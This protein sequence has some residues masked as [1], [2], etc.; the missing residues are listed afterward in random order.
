[1]IAGLE[2]QGEIKEG[3]EKCQ[4][5]ID[6][7]PGRLPLEQV[8]KLH[9]VRRDRWVQ[10]RLDALRALAKPD[11]VAEMD[12]AVAARFKAA[13]SDGSIDALKAFLAYFGEQP[14][15]P[16]ARAALLE[17]LKWNN[18]ASDVEMSLWQMQ[19]PL[20]AGIGGP[21]LAEV[22]EFFRNAQRTEAAAASYRWLF[23]RF[24]DAVC[25]DG[26]TG[27][28]LVE[29]I[30]PDSPLRKAIERRD[31][32]PTGNVE[33][34]IEAAKTAPDFNS[35]G[36]LP[37]DFR[38]S[39]GPFFDGLNL[40]YDQNQNRMKIVCS[41][42]TGNELWQ[43][44]LNDDAQLPNQGFAFGRG[45]IQVQAW[46]HV[47]FLPLGGRLVAIDTLEADRTHPPKLL[48]AEDAGSAQADLPVRQQ[49]RAWMNGAFNMAIQ[50]GTY[51][52][53]AGD[54]T[55]VTNRYVAVQRSR[56]LRVLSPSDGQI[57]WQREGVPP[58]CTLFGDDELLF[59]LPPDKVEALVYRAAD[60]EPLGSRQ[61]ERREIVERRQDGTKFTWYAPLAT[62]CLATLGR[63]LLY[64][65]QVGDRR[66]LDLVD[67]WQQKSLW[68]VRSFSSKAQCELVNREVLGVLETNGK[69]ALVNVSDGSTIFEA[70]LQPE[71]NLSDLILIPYEQSYLVLTSSPSRIPVTSIQSNPVTGGGD[72]QIQRG[73][74]YGIDQHGKFLWPE[75]VKISNQHLVVGQP[76]NFPTLVFASQIYEAQ[77]NRPGK[78][79]MAVQ[80]IDKRTGRV[81]FDKQDLPQ[82][83]YFKVSADPEKKTMQIAVQKN[84]ITLTFTDKPWPT[85][86]EVEKAE[87]EKKKNQPGKS[88]F[89]ALKN[90]AEET[91]K[92]PEI[93]NL[94]DPFGQ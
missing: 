44:P 6:L 28:Q 41:D 17:K 75:P 78:I 18:R 94:E 10:A 14:A 60:G 30:A 36:R 51:G 25:R 12:A 37:L 49:A 81:V 50:R 57:F 73:R 61:V 92:L 85:K 9:A 72:K 62:E 5:L 22:G 16:Q 80:F 31:P 69:F 3:L 4:S 93:E 90:A 42:P 87:A 1:M 68:P 59:V 47:L 63:N 74:L 43:F 52:N 83:G 11:V 65:R 33:I 58:A 20:T 53:Q 32:W 82:P 54:S 27:R 2:K 29:A 15:A 91:F 8:S 86:E 35:Y 76:Q 46:G 48:W 55:L 67:A 23:S 40:V 84:T 77:P 19:P 13:Q 38:G 26:K 88:L 71:N 64:W 66:T 21:A 24:A 34:D 56:T 70:Q 39:R 79:R 89:K 45:G 7:D